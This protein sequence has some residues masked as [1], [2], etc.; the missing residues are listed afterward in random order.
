[1][2]WLAVRFPCLPL[3][4]GGVDPED[5]ETACAVSEAG[6]GGDRILLA[7]SRAAAA[8]V[9]PG[10][11]PAAARALVPGLRL[12]RRNVRREAQALESLAA[13]AL[14]FSAEVSL[15][16]PDTLL[17]EVA[18]SRRLFGGIQSLVNAMRQSLGA[19]G[20]QGRL[21]LAPTPQ[22]ALLFVRAGR[23]CRVPDLP[24]LQARLSE[25]PLT[26]LPLAEDQVSALY[27]A[28][29]RR[30]GDLLTLPRAALGERLGGCF[31][32]WW[33]RLL[34]E[35]PDPL[36]LFEP[37]RIF[38]AS[39]EF[40]MPADS[41]QAL[42]FPARRLLVMLEGFL[43]ARQSAVQRLEWRLDH[44]EAPET[45]FALGFQTPLRE[46]NCMLS[47][48]GERLTGFRLVAPVRR[49]CLCAGRLLP[50]AGEQADSLLHDAMRVPGSG[51]LD[52]LRA[53][54]GDDAVTGIRLAGDHRP[55]HAMQLC[56]PGECGPDL[57]FPERPLWLLSEPRLLE[58]RDGRPWWRGPL[59]LEGERER[60][61]AGWW[62]GRPARRDYFAASTAEGRRLWVFLEREQAR[63]WFL[64]GIFG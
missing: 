55:E 42:L 22:G 45:R 24:A 37:P 19:M 29:L 13:W 36:P 25:V 59:R 35:V 7:N 53:R 12:V 58:V 52:R 44:D 50:W 20:Q 6:H 10:F 56:T 16:P 60:I 43:R 18:G 62:D 14:Q 51:L 17:V 5:P 3:E 11:T 28:G 49:L 32:G 61:E 63:Q 26:A 23:Q 1:M 30:C 33:A 8:G 34:G 31:L 9:R 4:V 47:L 15:A 40:P 21:V 57:C 2:R 27:T 39:V 64:H 54:M 41:T 38:R 46:G 48:L